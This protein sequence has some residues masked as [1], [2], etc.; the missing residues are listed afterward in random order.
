M[1][2]PVL[3]PAVAL[4]ML[5]SIVAIAERGSPSARNRAPLVMP[6]A[7]PP[8]MVAPAAP[9][10][11]IEVAAPVSAAEIRAAKVST[12]ITSLADRVQLKSHPE[13]LRL[14]FHAYFNFRAAHPEQVKKPYLYFVDY[15]LDNRTPR[16]YVFDM[17]SLR[18]IDGPFMVAHG[19][20][21]LSSADGVP[22]RFTNR[23]GSASTS[24]GLYVAQETYNF[25]G[26]S[27]GGT[28]RSIGLRLKGV[29]GRFNSAARARGVVVHGA[30][31]VTPGR[32][33][34][35]EG[36]PA[37]EPERAEWLIP[38]IANGGLVFLFSP[39]D[40]QWMQEEPWAAHDLVQL[41]GSP[42]NSQ[43]R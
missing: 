36:C 16:G 19:R 34:R 32:A 9:E 29:S 40:P 30:P 24:L 17:E 42:L 38:E 2:L 21:S 20:G 13:A 41:A 8:A 22:T 28:Y 33:G 26:H 27:G 15:G 37:M 43:P 31:Y 35:S 18:L 4:L 1:R 5:A 6:V 39:H 3:V 11:K 14:A 12:A 10:V 7:A 23:E 25:V